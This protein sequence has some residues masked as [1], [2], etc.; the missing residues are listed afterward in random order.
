MENLGAQLY[1]VM[2]ISISRIVSWWPARRNSGSL[3]NIRVD[4][5]YKSMMARV[6]GEVE[7]LSLNGGGLQ[8][9]PFH[10]IFGDSI[11]GIQALLL[12]YGMESLGA[13]YRLSGTDNGSQTKE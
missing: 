5:L 8:D 11:R 13:V 1:G 6:C 3:R 10:I 7:S 2:E 4:D 12:C 9:I